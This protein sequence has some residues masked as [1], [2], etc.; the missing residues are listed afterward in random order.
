MKTFLILFAL[1]I[2]S[3]SLA[4]AECLE[5]VQQFSGGTCN[6]VKKNMIGGSFY[7]CQQANGCN[8]NAYVCHLGWTGYYA[9]AVP[10]NGTRD[11]EMAVNQTASKMQSDCQDSKS[12]TTAVTKPKQKH[13]KACVAPQ[14]PAADPDDGCVDPTPD[15]KTAAATTAVSSCTGQADG[16]SCVDSNKVAGSCK[17]E[18]C[19]VAAPAPGGAAANGAYNSDS[20]ADAA[21]KADPTKKFVMVKQLGGFVGDKD[22]GTYVQHQCNGANGDAKGIVGAEGYSGTTGPTMSVDD[23]YK[24][25]IS[26]SAQKARD[27]AANY[28]AQAKKESDAATDLQ[29]QETKILNGDLSGVAKDPKAPST[30]PAPPPIAGGTTLSGLGGGAFG[31]SGG[32]GGGGNADPSTP[33]SGTNGLGGGGG[34]CGS[35]GTVAS[36]GSGVV[37]ISSTRTAASTTGSPT[38]TTSGSNTIYKFT[39]TGSITY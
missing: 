5:T 14:T 37:I 1:I 11:D 6:L 16:T 15:A 13:P 18:V 30:A 21:C 2:S 27:D 24:K 36:G 25:N 12:G 22:S 28:T 38:V 34:G 33:V 3:G 9:E 32:L 4:H 19:L 23:I 31:G 20:D 26:D 17:S 29:D 8:T 7:A 10:A 35:G 39:G